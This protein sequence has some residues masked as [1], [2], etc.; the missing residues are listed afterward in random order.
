VLFLDEMAEF[1]KQVLEVLRQ[2]LEDRTVT[3]SRVRGTYT[4]P[5]QITLVAAMNP[6]PCGYLGDSKKQC[7]CSASQV[8]K[9]R[10]RIS[11]PL[12]D[13]IDLQ[14]EMPALSYEE[15]HFSHPGESSLA[16]AQRVADARGLQARRFGS[17][18]RYNAN[19]SHKEVERYCHLDPAGHQLLKTALDRLR[20]SGRAHDSILKVARTIADLAQAEQLGLAHLAEAVNYRSLDRQLQF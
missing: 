2:P 5:S 14:I 9:Y 12:M 16:I 1:P 20:L 4:F 11:G 3:V 17:W 7:Q 13:R 6:C 18:S 8:L 15:I 19:M 10:G